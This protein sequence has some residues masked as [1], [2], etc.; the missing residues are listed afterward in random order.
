M[1]GV[2]SYNTHYYPVF[3]HSKLYSKLTKPSLLAPYGLGVTKNYYPNT[4]SPKKYS[5][6]ACIIIF[7]CFSVF[8][9]VELEERE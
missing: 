1:T 8:L 2:I 7:I 5:Q 9:L 3:P 4:L 6:Y